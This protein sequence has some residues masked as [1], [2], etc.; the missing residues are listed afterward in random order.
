MDSD[1][2]ELNDGQ[3]V[4]DDDVMMDDE[5]SE[6]SDVSSVIAVVKGDVANLNDLQDQ[7]D[8]EGANNE[9]DEGA[10]EENEGSEKE[11]PLNDELEVLISNANDEL[12]RT[13]L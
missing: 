6:G 4:L 10:N 12:S 13:R 5:V 3:S 1:D 2:D 9:E 11:G 7:D 8:E